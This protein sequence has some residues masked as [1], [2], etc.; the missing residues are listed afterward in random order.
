MAEITTREELITAINAGLKPKYV[1]FWGHT[2]S[3]S[4]LGQECLS[5]WYPSRFVVHNDEYLTAEH[6]M[7][8][9]KAK[10]FGDEEMRSRILA[11]QHPAEAKKLGRMVRGFRQEVWRAQRSAIVVGGNTAK[12]DQDSTL[13][14][15]LLRTGDRILVEASPRDSIWG[16]GL[17]ASDPEVTNPEKWKGLNLLG[18]ALMIVRARL[19]AD[20]AT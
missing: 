13:K 10:L 18:F 20:D 1:L 7:M 15:Y 4:T 3:E 9:E 11:A 16:V 5:Q 14:D 2:S 8:A 12:F 17:S 6:W 19:R